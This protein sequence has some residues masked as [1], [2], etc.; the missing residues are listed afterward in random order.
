MNG[1]APFPQ[2]PLKV[3]LGAGGTRIPYVVLDVFTTTQL[4]GN[5]LGVFTDARE[6]GDATMQRL[7]R[8]LNYAESVFVL[9]PRQDADL[10]IRIFTPTG[11]LPFAG[12]PVL[13]AAVAAATAL[14][15][16]EI[17]LET[18]SGP[19]TITLE[20]TGGAVVHGRFERPAPPREP[21]ARA[22]EL[23]AALGT[24]TSLLPVEAYRNGPVH[25]YVAL[26]DEDAVAALTPDFVTLAEVH[27]G[28]VSCF[29]GAGTRWSTRMFAPA[30][31]VPEDP[32]TGSAAGPLALHLARHGQIEFGEQIEIRQG[33]SI[34]RPSVLYARARGTAAS[35]D[36]VEVGGSALVVARGD[37]RLD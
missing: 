18:E 34:G 20:R 22:D 14:D 15:R 32:A 2:L 37:F 27:D 36:S 9:P 4:E 33:S 31:G 28:G 16:D 35:A 11:E 13:G 21:F 24:E 5:Q 23:L 29:A 30:M 3:E 19:V 12:H 17:T 25:V 1:T 8:E 6:L 26:P 10:R 7:A